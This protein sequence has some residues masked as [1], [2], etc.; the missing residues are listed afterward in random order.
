MGIFQML[1]TNRSTYASGETKMNVQQN[2]RVGMDEIAR[3]LRM[4]GYFPE[5]F[6]TNS[7]NNLV[8]VS[9]IQLATDNA[10]AIFGDGSTLTE[11]SLVNVTSTYQTATQ[12]WYITLAADEK[13]LAAANV[14]NKVVFLPSFTQSARYR[15]MGEVEMPR[16]YACHA[17]SG[18]AGVDSANGA[19]LG[20]SGATVRASVITATTDQQ[21]QQSSA[22]TRIAQASVFWPP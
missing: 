12:G 20:Q 13:V 6:D 3:E 5:N 15:A 2:A 19:I 16:L 11:S 21:I 4:T 22:S 7:G 14:F 8:N 17:T 1:E 9:A 18:Y 10:L